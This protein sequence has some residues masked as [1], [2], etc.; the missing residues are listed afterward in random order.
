MEADGSCVIVGSRKSLPQVYIATEAETNSSNLRHRYSSGSS[1][2]G[3]PNCTTPPI[4]TSTPHHKANTMPSFGTPGCISTK[5]GSF[6]P[7]SYTDA[8]VP[9][10]SLNNDNFSGYQYQ[11]QFSNMKKSEESIRIDS[12]YGRR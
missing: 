4:S 7:S 12:G 1:S 9:P 2:T 10:L 3:T 8:Y 11:D 6:Q 5:Y